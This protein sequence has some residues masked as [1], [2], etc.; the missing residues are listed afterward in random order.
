MHLYVL[1]HLM[2]TENLEGRINEAES[3]THHHAL[4][5]KERLY[6]ALRKVPF[7]LCVAND[8][9]YRTHTI[10]RWFAVNRP[11][12]PTEFTP[13]LRERDVGPFAGRPY[14]EVDTEA[15]G[16]EG[17]AEMWTRVSRQIDAAYARHPHGHVLFVTHA[18]VSEVIS[19]HAKD[20][21]EDLLNGRMHVYQVYGDGIRIRA[22][23]SAP[24]LENI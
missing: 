18:G 24:Y 19:T 10:G 1:R 2:T 9:A 3:R 6:E 16:V 21:A 14:H 7:D 8:Q 22:L 17:L 11:E 20:A 15:P 23:N 13:D 5:D 12:V 4:G